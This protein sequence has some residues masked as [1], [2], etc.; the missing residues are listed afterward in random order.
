MLIVWLFPRQ[1]QS[2]SWAHPAFFPAIALAS[3]TLVVVLSLI[4]WVEAGTMRRA[5]KARTADVSQLPAL[6]PEPI[7]L[8]LLRRIPDPL[9]WLAKPIW[10]TTWGLALFE[11][12]QDAELGGKPSRYLLLLIAAAMAGGFIGHRIGGVLLGFALAF[13]LP[14]LP[15]TLIRNRAQTYRRRFGEQLPQALDSFASGLSAGLSFEQA[16]RF[17][18]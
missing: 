4:L 8:W 9:E 3:A 11:E 5:W 17:A 7:I 12:W 18:E 16:I 10:R 13:I 2:A 6:E 1:L 14:I 15:R